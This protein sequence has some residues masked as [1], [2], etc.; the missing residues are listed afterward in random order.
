MLKNKNKFRIQGDLLNVFNRQYEIVARY[1]MPGRS[2]K[3]SVEF[4]M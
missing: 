2:W 3:I 4:E 1:P